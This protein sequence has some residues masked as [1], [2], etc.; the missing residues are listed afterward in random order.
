[1]L[2]ELSLEWG[3]REQAETLCRR[4]LEAEPDNPR[5]SLDLG[6]VA[7]AGHDPAAA[8]PHLLRAAESP[9][10]RRAACTMLAT[11]YQRRGE[12]EMA[13]S[14]SRRAR[15]LPP[16]EG[17][18][19][20]IVDH[21]QE[22]ATG[23][24]PRLRKAQRLQVQGRT[25]EAVALL[26]RMTA[27]DPSDTNAL[28]MLGALLTRSGN[29]DGAEQALR[30]AADLAP[31]SADP[32][33]LL[34][35]ALYQQGERLREGGGEA[36][37][38]KYRAAADAAR[39]ATELQPDHAQAHGYLGLA[40]KRLG[41]RKEAIES[42]R[43]AVRCWPDDADGHLALGEALAEDGRRAEART[44][45]QYA[46]DLAG[47]DDPRPRQALERLRASERPKSWLLP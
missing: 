36:A 6:L 41:R 28:V 18:S 22:Y 20:P 24:T 39:R 35:V 16:D 8:I 45:L 4:V 2:A 25:R 29:L 33:Y 31:R 11:A 12:T 21:M 44:E 19:D 1:M 40:L 13:A 7:L 30:R 14:Y 34:A 9:S 15:Q 17:W 10:A 27:D 32:S 37:A 23:R 3:D 5:A 43:T 47:P 46:C 38:A 26:Q 42:L